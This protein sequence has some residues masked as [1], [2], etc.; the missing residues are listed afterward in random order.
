MAVACAS[1]IGCGTTTKQGLIDESMRNP[2]MRRQS[3][4]ATLRVLDQHPEYVDEMYQ[5]TRQRHPR[6]MGRFLQNSAR[7]LEEPGL[8]KVTA[9]LLAENPRSL[10]QVLLA[11]VDATAPKRDAREAL[12]VA[13]E[14]RTAVMADVITDRPSTVAATLTDTVA[15]VEKK[16]PART[17]FLGAMQK[18]AP[19]VAEILA[20]DPRTLMVLTEALVR[21]VLKDKEAAKKLAEM[22][23]AKIEGKAPPAPGAPQ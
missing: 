11:T 23:A 16:P 21:E 15:A 6:T 10:R 3:F 8:A 14:E 2:A 13:V 19:R 20:K 1:V 5:A 17:A 18:S 4:E 22:I 9:E 7:D 12:A